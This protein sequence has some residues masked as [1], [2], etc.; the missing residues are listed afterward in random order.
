MEYPARLGG[1][2]QVFRHPVKLNWRAPVSRKM[3]KPR[4]SLLVDLKFG[5]AVKYWS[6]FQVGLL[7]RK[8]NFRKSALSIIA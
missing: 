5:T 3:K 4:Q 2:P 6:C 7:T 1:R 8:E